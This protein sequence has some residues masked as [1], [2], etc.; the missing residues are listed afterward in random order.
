MATEKPNEIPSDYGVV[1]FFRH[2][3][4]IWIH[5][6]YFTIGKGDEFRSSAT[7]GIPWMGFGTGH[8]D[9]LSHL[10]EGW[11]KPIQSV[12]WDHERKLVDVFADDLFLCPEC[13]QFYGLGH[14]EQNQHEAEYNVRAM[15]R[16]PKKDMGSSE[17]SRLEP[18]DASRLREFA[19]SRL[20]TPQ[21]YMQPCKSQ[22]CQQIKS[23]AIREFK[24]SL[25]RTQQQPSPETR[26]F[27]ESKQKPTPTYESLVYLIH[28]SGHYKI[29]I[30]VDAHKRL[31]GIQTSCPFPVEIVKTWKSGNAL[32]VEQAIHRRFGGHRLKGEWFKL[33]DSVLATLKNIEDIDAEFLSSSSSQ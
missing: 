22:F 17:W 26:A 29:G 16:S 18:S 33:P 11:P 2:F 3:K 12:Q 7:S 28:G 4:Q 13:G 8:E 21:F 32:A 5:E 31:K 10:R 19:T 14:E 27:L 23:R 6:R 25:R 20:N 15:I 24:S 30:A 9:L 1:I